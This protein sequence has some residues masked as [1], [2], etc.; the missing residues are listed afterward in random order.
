M[1]PE[2]AEKKAIQA[3]QRAKKR[4]GSD[5]TKEEL[6]LIRETDEIAA[7]LEG[8][9]FWEKMKKQAREHGSTL[10]W[11]DEET[12]LWNYL[13]PNGETETRT[14]EENRE[15]IRKW[16]EEEAKDKNNPLRAF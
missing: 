11:F 13:H 16:E 2:Q 12:Q 4:A 8:P 5:I 7:A 3:L 1:K 14:V 6:D 9:E 10:T 15:A